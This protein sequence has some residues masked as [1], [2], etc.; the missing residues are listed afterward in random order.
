MRGTLLCLVGYAS[1]QLL[2][3][4]GLDMDQ[5]NIVD[6]HLKTASI[7]FSFISDSLSSYWASVSGC[8][9]FRF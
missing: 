3:F 7:F 4:V 1:E 6:L 8:V 9:Q 5:Q 2:S